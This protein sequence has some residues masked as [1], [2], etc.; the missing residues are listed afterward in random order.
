MIISADIMNLMSKDQKIFLSKLF[1]NCPKSLLP[2]IRFMRFDK[3]HTLISAT[4][5]C[6]YVYILLKGRLQ[7]TDE[8][9][10]DARYSF[11]E[12]I[13][14]DIVGDFELFTESTENSVTLT[15][16]EESVFL[17]IPAKSYLNWIRKD[18]NALFMRTQMLMHQLSRQSQNDRQ[19]LFLDNRTRFHSYLIREWERRN[20]SACYTL[21][22]TRQEIAEKLGCSI[23]TLN[24][25][26][27]Q[28]EKEELL[29]ILKGKIHLDPMHYK[30]LKFE[31]DQI[32][33]QKT[34]V[35]R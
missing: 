24:R 9:L 35:K 1:L 6:S 29:S 14:V 22:F 13:P 7:A 28:A 16:L 8:W 5:S 10:P 3:T 34:A 15:T 19:N 4:G 17:R 20:L 2:E 12:I 21:P 33:I 18:A 11:T 32:R 31:A 26:V 23:R 25:L 30:K 27:H